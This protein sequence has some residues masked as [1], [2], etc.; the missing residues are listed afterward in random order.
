MNI[1]EFALN[2]LIVWVVA[3]GISLLLQ[4]FQ[5]VDVIIDLI[6]AVAFALFWK[7]DRK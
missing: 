5:P 6:V 7:I 1:Y 2:V 4:F 3:M